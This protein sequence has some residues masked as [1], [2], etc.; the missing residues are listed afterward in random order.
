[1]TRSARLQTLVAMCMIDGCEF[2]EEATFGVVVV[3]V[4]TDRVCAGLSGCGI[5]I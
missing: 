4:Q 2:G 3:R 1:M 5:G